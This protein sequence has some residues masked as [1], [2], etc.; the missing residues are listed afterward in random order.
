MEYRRNYKTAP[1][2]RIEYR[3]FTFLEA[4]LFAK[5]IGGR[6]PG[7][8][9]FRKLLSMDNELHQK[10]RG[11][12]YWVMVGKDMSVPGQAYVKAERSGDIVIALI[13]ATNNTASVMTIDILEDT[14]SKGRT[15]IERLKKGMR[16]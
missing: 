16:S 4:E 8:S 12:T 6:L 7:F 10:A 2:V 1:K 14:V 13:N 15:S 11:Y 5:S 3:R 9:E